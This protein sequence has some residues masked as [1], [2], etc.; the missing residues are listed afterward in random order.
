MLKEASIN[1]HEKAAIIVISFLGFLITSIIT[2]TSHKSPRLLRPT[3]PA[4]KCCIAGDGPSPNAHHAEISHLQLSSS[5]SSMSP[6][7][8]VS[9]FHIPSI[10]RQDARG[11]NL[12]PPPLQS[13]TFENIIEDLQSQPPEFST[14]P[15]SEPDITVGYLNIRKLSATKSMFIASFMHHYKIDVLF[16][17][18]L[19]VTNS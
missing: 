14:C 11:W 7:Q 10:I 2:Q 8:H 13:S 18:D 17:L 16:L 9:H 4:Y 12:I 3:S 15:S 5:L 19:Q 6:T 1:A